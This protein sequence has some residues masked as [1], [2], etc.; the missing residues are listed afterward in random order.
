MGKM[1]YSNN[2]QKQNEIEKLQICIC[3]LLKCSKGT[4]C[5]GG[6]KDQEK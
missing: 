2:T 1:V 6:R 5:G 4:E 3:L